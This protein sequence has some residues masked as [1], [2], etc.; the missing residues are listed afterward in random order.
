MELREPDTIGGRIFLLRKQKNLSLKK[1]SELSKVSVSNISDIERY[2]FKTGRHPRPSVLKNIAHALDTSVH[3]LVG[4][5]T[6]EEVL[7]RTCEKM[8]IL[9]M[10]L[11]ENLERIQ[12]ELTNLL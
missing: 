11:I 3:Y 7:H 8:M 6:K 2:I 9:M 4:I 1:L 5:P 10:D 12:D